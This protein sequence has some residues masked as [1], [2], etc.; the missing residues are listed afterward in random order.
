MYALY[1]KARQTANVDIYSANLFDL[2]PTD[3]ERSECSIF[4][5]TL[6]LRPIEEDLSYYND[7]QIMRGSDAIGKNESTIYFATKSTPQN[8]QVADEPLKD[9]SQ[10]KEIVQKSDE[11]QTT[12]RST[13]YGSSIINGGSSGAEEAVDASSSEHLSHTSQSPSSWHEE[14]GRGEE[15]DKPHHEICMDHNC[16]TKVC[17]AREEKIQNQEDQIQLLKYKLQQYKEKLN[18]QQM[19]GPLNFEKDARTDNGTAMTTHK[20]KT[21]A[22]MMG[23]WDIPFHVEILPTGDDSDEESEITFAQHPCKMSESFV[24]SR[25]CSAD[26][27][28]ALPVTRKYTD[29][30]GTS[31]GKLQ[32]KTKHKGTP[33][34]TSKRKKQLSSCPK[35][36]GDQEPSPQHKDSEKRVQRMRVVVERKYCLQKAWYS[37]TVHHQSGIPHGTGSLQFIESKDRY[38]GEI[39]YGEMH[40]RGTYYFAKKQKI[41]R[42]KSATRPSFTASVSR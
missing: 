27:D 4:Q 37:G 16:T 26:D 39:A 34:Q 40:G 18:Q 35:K 13:V 21:Y 3:E 10:E 17:R 20:E 28:G 19:Y 31:N 12:C 22:D 29:E 25:R 36:S 6:S 32:S 2:Y 30:T 41:F 33:S 42:A 15:E 8:A 14:L 23:P 38:I 7:H 1:Q 9:N 24:G 5:P 11:T